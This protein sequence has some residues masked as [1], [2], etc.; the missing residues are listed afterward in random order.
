MT[1]S[2][3]ATTPSP[4]SAIRAGVLDP[5]AMD[6]AVR[7]QDDLYRYVS[8]TWLREAEI[9]ADRA[10]TGAFTQLRDAAEEAC[11]D[12][13]EKL[14][15]QENL[16]LTTPAG[17]VGELYR[18]FMDE[19][20]IEA[21]GAQPLESDIA[22]IQSISSKEELASFMGRTIGTLGLGAFGVDVESDLD[23]PDAY[24]TWVGQGGIGLPDESYYREDAH[25]ATREAYR[26]H[27]TEILRLAS[28]SNPAERTA[29][30][31]AV[32]EAL[33]K[34][35]WDR[36]K[37][38]DIEAMNNRRSWAEI[39]ASAP[40]FPMELWREG[41]SEAVAAAGVEKAQDELL[42]S[43]AIVAQP[44][45]LT[46]VGE[47]WQEMD[48]EAWKAWALWHVIHGRAGLLSRDFAAAN[49]EFFS[50]HLQGIEEQRPRWK[51]AVGLVEGS[52]GEALGEL[53]V[54]RHFP[55][56]YKAQMEALVEDLIAAYHESISSLEWM[57][58]ETRQRALDKL[59][60][61][62]PKIGYPDK[63]RDYSAVT[64]VP[65]DVITSLDSVV[66][67]EF[68]RSLRKLGQPMDRS[69]WLMTPQTVNAYYDPTKNEI[70]FPAAILQP[71]FFNPEADMAVNYAAIGGVIGHEIGHGFDDQGATFD[72]TGKVVNWWTEADLAAFRERTSALIAQYDAYTPATLLAKAKREGTPT[73]Q[74]PH[75][76]G[77]LTIG[78]NIGDL[79][80]LSIALKAY[81]LAL[82]RQGI[83]DVAQAPVIDGLTA[84]ERFFFS[85]ALIW[86]DKARE[87]RAEYLITV[88]PHSPTE[89]RCNG[90]V[91]NVEAFY[92]TFNVVEGDALYLPPEQRVSIW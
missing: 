46:H 11:R 49:F 79:G 30:A 18:S 12:I 84:M 81:K 73:D 4:D 14:A 80:G 68:A 75:V 23:D 39:V 16:D 72:G 27:I 40:G 85:W 63:W 59:A 24:V 32:E 67:M 42:L 86:R 82:K 45:Y 66:A 28:L 50:R 71:P 65:G 48:L 52:L 89:F 17:K 13:L 54:A 60:Q 10:S 57:G 31:Y 19:E 47:V 41:V 70:C 3:A 34:G 9:P 37:T 20:V 56:E 76:N 58:E 87:E 1:H 43:T 92:E 21:R 61:F 36:V 35:H 25:A 88:D 51:R 38:R 15:A 69:E 5:A 22:A 83:K 8:G 44:D 78:E 29:Q 74:I 6:P 2:D 26:E 91:R 55:P 62:T 64:V 33:A 7:P 90:I 77:S 53:Y